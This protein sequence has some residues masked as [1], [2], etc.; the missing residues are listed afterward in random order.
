[1]AWFLGVY[2][3]RGGKNLGIFNC[4]PVRGS[5]STT[6]L[7]GEGRAVDF[8]INPHGAQY[9]T[10]LANRLMNNSAALGIQCIIW[11]RRIWSGSYATQGFRPYSG[12]NPHVDHLHVELS[13]AAAANL[14]AARA[15]QIMA[16]AAP[17]PPAGNPT[18]PA[19]PPKPTVRFGE[20]HQM[21]VYSAEPP[22]DAQGRVTQPKNQWARRTVTF[23]F[24]PATTKD[25]RLHWGSRGGWLHQARWWVRTK[26]WS[27]N[28]PKHGPVDHSV[29]QGGSERHIGYGWQPTPPPGADELEVTFSA[30]D[31]L[32]IFPTAK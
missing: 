18:S 6:S 4:R 7:H 15:A 22:K 12:V 24:D 20:D 11:N 31:G 2:A 8:G 5:T 13:R 9:G 32:H 14:T 3:A 10:D 17:V 19:A 23:G 30:P 25:L 27:P 29:G 28:N 26:D 1:M 21:H 16:T